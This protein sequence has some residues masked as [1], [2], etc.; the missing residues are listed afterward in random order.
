MT[1][2]RISTCATPATLVLALSVFAPTL[3]SA[4]ALTQAGP[5]ATAVDNAARTPGRSEAPAA[6]QASQPP[7][8]TSANDLK[9]AIY[10]V[11]V[12]VPTFGAEA[13]VPSFP[14][15][16]GGPDLPGGSGSTTSSL[17]G[18]A[19]A[20]LSLQKAWWRVDAQG[21]W[22]AL[23]TTRDTPLLEVDLDVVYGHVS[24][25]VKVYKDLYV[26]AGVR[27]FALKYDIKLGTRPSFVRKPGLWDPLIGLGWHGALGPRWDL[28]L[29]GEGGGFGAGADV[30]LG[31]TARADWKVAHHVGLTFGYSV[32]YL[33][34]SD[35]VLQ[36]TL[37]VK[38][39]LQGPE[40][41][42]GLYF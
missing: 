40:L 26:T 20:G 30:D 4:Q 27:R 31:A 34:V 5:L 25:G 41:G 7:V 21:M 10:P 38:Q 37:T 28:H 29:T 16:P 17:E 32:L 13:D 14:D 22:G 18:A 19:L 33:K 24:G 36:R 42:L 12:W 8:T 3:V 11:L 6:A 1:K 9:V 23:T 15:V 35:T 39:T 2:I